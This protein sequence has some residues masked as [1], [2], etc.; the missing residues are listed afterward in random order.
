MKRTLPILSA[1]LLGAVLPQAHVAAWLIRWLVTWM[2]FA[3]F[4]R[5][6]LS[7][8][9]IHRSHFV[10]LVANFAVGFAAWLVAGW[11]GGHE[12]G[13]AAF[14]CG[15]TPTAIAAPVIVSFLRGRVSYVTGAFLLSNLAVAA[16][17]PLILPFVLGR[18]TPGVF[19]QVAQSMGGV[20]FGPFVLAWL[21]RR[22]WEAAAD[23]AGTLGNLN[24]GV[25]VVAIF[26]IT[27]N[28]SHFL[29]TQSGLAPVV[30]VKIAVAALV[31]CVLSFSL[32][33]WIGG[34]E[35]AAEASQSL[36]QKNTT[37]TIYLAMAYASPLVA[38]GPTFYVIWHNLWNSWQLH[39]Q[40]RS[41]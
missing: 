4:L 8:E 1:M 40:G 30:V 19:A 32:G 29:R 22:V 38:L 18:P 7:R 34:R 3:V 13:L 20:V 2:L 10:L 17:M 14:F 11:W 27:A 21:V 28:A 33:R 15:I 35:F 12:V 26:L 24:F 31:I 5:T 6:P 37:F 41:G 16:A 9:T 25:W 36:G 23:W 39:R